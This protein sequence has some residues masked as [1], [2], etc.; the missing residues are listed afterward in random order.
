MKKCVLLSTLPL[1]YNDIGSWTILYDFLLNSKN[2]V[3]IIICP[4]LN[5]SIPEYKNSSYYYS[6]IRHL[7]RISKYFRRYKYLDYLVTIK[8]IIK[9]DGP[10]VV[11]VIDNT[12]LLEELHKYM[13][14]GGIRDKCR[15]VYSM[16]GF[17]YF[18]SSQKGEEFY[19]MIDHVIFLTHSSYEFEVNR[20]SFI[21][22]KVSVLHDGVDSSKFYKL[23]AREKEEAKQN[24]GY[25]NKKVFIWVSQ[26]R[27]KKGLHILLEAWNNSVAK[28]RDDVVLIVIGTSK[29]ST[30][31]NIQ[32]LGKIPNAQLPVWYNISDYYFFTSLVHEGFGLSLIEAVKCGCTAMASDILPMREVLDNGRLGF[33]VS[34]P[35]N[36]ESW[37]CIINQI[38]SGSFQSID[39]SREE[40][41]SLY[42]IKSWCRSMNTIIQNEKKSFSVLNNSI[43]PE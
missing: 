6:K 43:F 21:T 40:L 37:T 19:E 14:K 28:K 15:I 42:D 4:P 11:K 30:E 32:Y 18:F 2:E 9:Q 26:E 36:P 10:I 23:S 34:S 27:P 41:D 12:R 5:K 33:L 39:L 20:Y 35:H 38:L 25:E 7:N 8:K 13:I 31:G 1:P 22:P 3:D 24:F 16:H 29:I 17:S